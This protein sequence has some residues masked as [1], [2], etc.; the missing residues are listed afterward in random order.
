[1]TDN[2]NWYF[3]NITEDI[4]FGDINAGNNLIVKRRKLKKNAVIRK[5]ANDKRI[6]TDTLPAALGKAVDR[7]RQ[8][9]QIQ[10]GNDNAHI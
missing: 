5:Y 2:N 9:N 4:I 7:Y 1:M 3:D 10:G 8:E 6:K